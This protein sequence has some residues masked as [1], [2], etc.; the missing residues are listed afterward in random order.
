MLYTFLVIT[1]MIEGNGER[2]D[3]YVGR[4]AA[5]GPSHVFTNKIYLGIRELILGCLNALC[6]F[7]RSINMPL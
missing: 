5:S 7:V 1:N 2:E 6:L 3:S 4:D